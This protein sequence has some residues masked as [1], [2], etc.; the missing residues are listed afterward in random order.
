MFNNT[1]DNKN[2]LTL[3]KSLLGCKFVCFCEVRI[4]KINNNNKITS[5]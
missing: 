1:T 2:V 4:Q 3:F 5:F